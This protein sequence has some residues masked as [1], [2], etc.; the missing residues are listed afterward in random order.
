MKQDDFVP[1]KKLRRVET[2][3]T[4]KYVSK[5]ELKLYYVKMFKN[6]TL[7]LCQI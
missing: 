1:C 3:S 4:R 5:R 2:N 6:F 7:L